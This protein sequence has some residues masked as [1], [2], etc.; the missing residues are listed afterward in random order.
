MTSER[1]K[2]SVGMVLLIMLVA[3]TALLWSQSA[4]TQMAKADETSMVTHSSAGKPHDDGFII[5]A[6]DVLAV[7]VW[8][9]PEISRAVPVRS[10]G[11]ISLPLV[12]EVQASGTTPRQLENDIAKRL[13]SYISQPDVTVIVQEI[14]SQR[15][16]VLGQV[17]RPGSYALTNSL[18]V[19]DA[20]ALSGGFRDFAKQKS[21]YVLRQKP[22][23]SQTRLAF[24]YKDVIKGKNP[25]Q[26]VRLEPRDTVVIP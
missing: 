1:L 2:N 17:V 22:D 8:K 4:T 18:T 15:F 14:K 11:K 10:D 13:E 5:G 24:N 7:N 6:D 20:I 26:N 25:A 12:G 16:N 23:G 19:L 21:I 9:E 3:S